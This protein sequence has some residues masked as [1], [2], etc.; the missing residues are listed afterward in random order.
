MKITGTSGYIK[1]VLIKVLVSWS[2]S[3]ILWAVIF[4]LQFFWLFSGLASLVIN[5]FPFGILGMTE[6]ILDKM[7]IKEGVNRFSLYLIIGVIS[8]I[9]LS[10]D[11]RLIC[12][13]L[14]NGLLYYMSK[15]V[16]KMLKEITQK[17]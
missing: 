16:Y 17:Y 11:W 10:L 6:F 15:H 14:F 9:W 3:S 1:K 4:P 5:L 8:L 2:I 12:I 13:G 7:K